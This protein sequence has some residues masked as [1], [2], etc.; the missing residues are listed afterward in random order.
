MATN[1]KLPD[2]P[3]GPKLEIGP[4]DNYPKDYPQKSFLARQFVAYAGPMKWGPWVVIAHHAGPVT[5][6]I[7]YSAEGSTQVIGAVNY[8]NQQGNA[9]TQQFNG[10][11]S[12]HTGN[13]YAG[14]SVA[15]IGRPFGSVV[16][17][18]V[19]P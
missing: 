19:Q 4:I 8:I 16:R 3:P 17:G 11:I 7:S 5:Y 6:S 18:S 2:P 13:V 10:A 12:I 9:V 15:F 14:V 1:S